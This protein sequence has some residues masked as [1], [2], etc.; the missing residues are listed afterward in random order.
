MDT[1]PRRAAAERVAADK[2][3]R[4]GTRTEERIEECEGARLSPSE[5][6]GVD[7]AVGALRASAILNHAGS[8]GQ[9]QHLFPS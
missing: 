3:C 2:L 1:R 5:Q 6:A 9:P 7:A 4:L 8:G